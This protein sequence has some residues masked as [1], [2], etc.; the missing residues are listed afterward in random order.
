MKKRNIENEADNLG[1]CLIRIKDPSHAQAHEQFY[2][3][4]RDWGVATW[5]PSDHLRNDPDRINKHTGYR[6][7]DYS[8][9]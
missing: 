2:A 1:D 4:A 7:K 9:H 8:E 5:R 6:G 3:I